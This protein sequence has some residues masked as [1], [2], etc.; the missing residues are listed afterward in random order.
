M[1]HEYQEDLPEE[2]MAD[3]AIS[4]MD[5]I[6]AAENKPAAPIS[7]NQHTLLSYLTTSTDLWTKAINIVKPEYFDRE[8]A[9]VIE[10]VQ[11]YYHKYGKLPSQI[12][13]ETKTG[14][15]LI[16]PPDPDDAETQDYISDELEI[17]CR[18]SAF[19]KFIFKCADVLSDTDDRADRNDLDAMMKEGGAIPNI[20]LNR[21]LGCEV[22]KSGGTLLRQAEEYSGLTTG[23]KLLDEALDGGVTRPSLNIV[24]AASGDG[25]SIW[26][27][28]MAVNYSEMGENVIFYSMELEPATLEHRFAAMIT[29]THIRKVFGDIGGMDLQLKMLGKQRGEIQIKKFPMNGTSMADIAAHHQE[30]TLQTGKQWP[31]VCI[32]YIDIMSPVTRVDKTNIHLKDKFVSEEMNEWLHRN[33]L[34]G[35]TASQQTKGS[36]D[37]KDA[38]QS[39]IAGGTPKVNTSDN[40]FVLKRSNEDRIEKRIWCHIVKARSAGGTGAKIP[41][42]WNQPGTLRMTSNDKD[43]DLF[44]KTNPAMFGVSDGGSSNN[45]GVTNEDLYKEDAGQKALAKDVMDKVRGK[46]K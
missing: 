40:T 23:L 8:N 13:I 1:D 41:L 42:C 25:K 20:S 38:K 36:Q 29:N 24:S 18:N 4:T 6:S 12:N 19:N 9:A 32:D 16:T 45:S 15:S 17:F 46:L 11:E 28:N 35:W 44:K 2:V 33:M 21:D 22:H 34:I 37:D 3:D 30:L 10:F 31:V 14:V 27:Q 43:M 7:K 26:L 5:K 39:G